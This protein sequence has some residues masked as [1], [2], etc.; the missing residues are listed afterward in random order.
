MPFI[1]KNVVNAHR[2]RTRLRN[3]FLKNRTESNRVSYNKQ[4]NFCVSLLRKT[5]KDYYGNLNEKDVIDNKKFWNTVKLLFSDKV[6]SSGKI[7]IVH[8]DKIITTDHENGKILNSFFSNVVKHLKTPEFKD[9]DFSAECIRHPALKAIM[10]FRKH[11]SVSA[12]TNAFNP[13][14][15]NFSKVSVDD[16][17]KEIKKLG[18]R[19]AIQNTDIPVKILKENADIFGS[20]ICHFLNV[21]VVK[22][23]FPSVL[24]H[25]D[26]TPVFKKGYTGSKEN[27][28][29]ASILPVISKIF[30]KLLCNQVT[31]F[32]DQFL[33]KYQCGFRKG[34]NAQHCLLAILEKWK[35][36]VDTK[37][38]F[39]T[40]LT[41]LSKAFDC[42][43]H[44]LII[45][46]LNAYEFSLPA[47]NLIQNYLANRKQ[48]TKINDSY[49][50]WSDILFGVPQ[51]SILGPL[52]FNIFLSDLFLIVKDV[53]MA[54]YADDNTLYDS[55]D[56]IEEV[57]SSLQS[58]SKKLFQWLSDN[59]MKGNTEKCHLIMS[60]DQ[61]VNFQFGGSLIERSDC[62]KMLGVKIDYKLNFDEYV[63]T[64]YCKANNKL[65]AL[66]R[67][68]PYMSVEKK[69]ILMNSLFNAQFNYCPLVCCT[70]VR[71][72]IS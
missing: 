5:K 43:P 24:K 42:L 53:N 27:Y 39:D 51:G 60:T 20:Y 23:T 15:L 41:D 47:L 11:P 2:K 61:T 16:V 63:K 13:Q 25:A 28:Q 48:R 9:I 45:A 22:G 12:I 14:S 55:C 8:E 72:T 68:T 56:T 38:V 50:P 36:A 26:I 30:E 6:K 59:Q 71:I 57:I 69:K 37:K 1:N 58:S 17:L 34:F 64:L 29:P 49:S 70:A 33:S 32:M 40:L 4:R 44:D 7:T 31:P 18:N 35:K 54:S 67:A 62:E 3:K 65:R 10:K 46:K 66:A 21:C 19:K 52:L